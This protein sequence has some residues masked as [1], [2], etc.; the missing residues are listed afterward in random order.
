MNTK[1]TKEKAIAV[2]LSNVKAQIGENTQIV[3]S[4]K[5]SRADREILLANN[6]LQEIIRGWYILVRPDV[7]TGDTAAWYANFWDFLRVYLP[8][9]FGDDYCLA[10]ESSLD[11]HTENPTIPSQVVVI[12]KQGAGN[13]KFMYD[14]SLLAY[15]D[16]KNFP[17]ERVRKHGI[18]VMSLP[19]SLCKVAPIYFEKHLRDAELA[20]RLIKTPAEL[21]RVLVQYNLKTAAARLLGAYEFLQDN[22]T[23]TTIK[24]DLEIAGIHV[25]AKNPFQKR[26][27]FLTGIKLPSPYAGRIQSMWAQARCDVI[28]HMPQPPGLPKDKM[29]YLHSLDAIQQYDA[30]N[31]LSI[32]GYQVTPELIARVRNN[33]W[34]PDMNTQDVD[35]KNALAARGYYNAFQKVEACVEQVLNGANAARVVR[36]NLQIWYQQLFSTSV[37]A[38]LLSPERLLGYRDDRVFIRNSRHS[39]PPK[40]AVLDAMEAFFTCLDKEPHAGVNAVLGHY[41]FV[42]I[43]PYMDGNGRLGRFLMN[44]FMAAGGYPWTVVRVDNRQAYISILEA[45][46]TDSNF[47]MEAFTKFI[48]TEMRASHSLKGGEAT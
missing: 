4:G 29:Q 9:R 12:A 40:E 26:Q 48:V 7:A 22:D 6:W 36:Q 23:V 8:H 15:V 11:L 32:E 17:Q 3:A 34:Q 25:T 30:Y 21:S 43:H 24:N 35:L 18:Y 47:S 38:G 45:T 5:I 31:S 46:H 28:E 14:T 20:L 33:Q 37:Q 42:F 44:V 39:P 41:F 27:P 19:Y 2:A 16:D 13:T 1:S 10:A